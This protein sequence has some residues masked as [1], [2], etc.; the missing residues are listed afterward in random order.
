MSGRS[1]F[2][3]VPSL[4]ALDERV[5]L[6]PV[7][8]A[9]VAEPLATDAPRFFPGIVSRV[10]AGDANETITIGGARTEAP[11]R[12]SIILQ[13]L[14]NPSLPDAADDS[15]PGTGVLRSTDSGRSW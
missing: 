12:P 8:P 4:E 15:R 7:T 6:S 14:A 9:L 1:C 5:N 2:R 13:R 11:T 3:F 10:S